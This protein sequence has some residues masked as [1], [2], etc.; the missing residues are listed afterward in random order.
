MHSLRFASV[1]LITALLL[2]LAVF[3]FEPTRQ[4][5][6]HYRGNS[7][8]PGVLPAVCLGGVSLLSIYIFFLELRLFLRSR[9]QGEAADREP[10][11]GLPIR[12]FLSRSIA[13]LAL[14]W[15]YILLWQMTYFV[16]ATIFFAVCLSVS[17]LSPGERTRR[18][19]AGIIAVLSLFSIIVWWIFGSLLKVH[20]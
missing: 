15:L 7:L 17:A 14:L 5:V 12:G 13:A 10:Q 4:L 18:R 11:T 8:G 2:V 3:L 19:L 20:L 9:S 1:C 16:P 6:A